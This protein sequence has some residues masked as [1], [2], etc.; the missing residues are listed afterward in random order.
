MNVIHPGRIYETTEL[1]SSASLLA[2]QTDDCSDVCLIRPNGVLGSLTL[3]SD[4][5]LRCKNLDCMRQVLIYGKAPHLF[6]ECPSCA[7]RHGQRNLF[8]VQAHDPYVDKLPTWEEMVNDL[9]DGT[10]DALYLGPYAVCRIALDRHVADM[11]E[12]KSKK[13]RHRA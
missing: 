5:I 13:H 6:T 11:L 3:S 10:L 1:K 12:T 2:V 9:N 4:A 7:T 8:S